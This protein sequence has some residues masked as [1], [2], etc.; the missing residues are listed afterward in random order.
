VPN[1]VCSARPVDAAFAVLVQQP[2]GPLQS[3]DRTRLIPVR[4]PPGRL[5]LASTGSMATA[6]AIGTV[7]VTDLA[8]IVEGTPGATITATPMKGSLL[9]LLAAS[10]LLARCRRVRKRD[11]RDRLSKPRVAMPSVS[12]ASAR[13]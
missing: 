4:F 12:L 13:G 3:R 2:V 9:P 10:L 5:R 7:G 1:G 11:P 8:A 6:K